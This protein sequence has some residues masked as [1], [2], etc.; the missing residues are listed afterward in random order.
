MTTH[1]PITAA[2]DEPLFIINPLTIGQTVMLRDGGSRDFE[3]IALVR[4][5]GPRTFV[6]AMSSFGALPVNLA[7]CGVDYLVSS[8][9]KYI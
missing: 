2:K 4:Q 5:A 3:F 6:D 1:Y 9:N 7:E 8:A